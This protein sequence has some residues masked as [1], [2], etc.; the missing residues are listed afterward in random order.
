LKCP[1]T[2]A[3]ERGHDDGE[4]EADMWAPRGAHEMVRG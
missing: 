2:T 1:P 3:R 4:D